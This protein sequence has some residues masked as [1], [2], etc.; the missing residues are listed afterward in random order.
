MAST[1]TNKTQATDRG[2]QSM[3]L[4]QPQ[5]EPKLAIHRPN[6][7]L[8]QFGSDNLQS[9]FQSVGGAASERE[10][11]D[12]GDYFDQPQYYKTNVKDMKPPIVPGS[13]PLIAKE[14]EMGQMP[15]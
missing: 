12:A 15:P 4:N 11:V 5:V 9:N 6:Q 1:R 2:V 3:D 10:A 7:S 13:A 8:P 14:E